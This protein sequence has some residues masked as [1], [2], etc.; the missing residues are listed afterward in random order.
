MTSKWAAEIGARYSVTQSL[1]A[2]DLEDSL[3]WNKCHTQAMQVQAGKQLSKLQEKPAQ[4]YSHTGQ[5]T[6]LQ[7]KDQELTEIMEEDTLNSFE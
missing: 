5:A 4:Q 1:S 6:S 7:T 2:S 3:R